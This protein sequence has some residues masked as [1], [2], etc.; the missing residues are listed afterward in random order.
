MRI[1]IYAV[2]M[3]PKCREPQG[4]LKSRDGL[5][6]LGEEPHILLRP[7]FHPLIPYV[8]RPLKHE[9]LH[10]ALQKSPKDDLQFDSP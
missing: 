4:N 9:I 2:L 6:R 1:P 10:E 5:L 7:Y 3:R 8:N